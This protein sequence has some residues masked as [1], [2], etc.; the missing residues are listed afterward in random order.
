V[1]L[2]SVSAHETLVS[3]PIG[4][5]QEEAELVVAGTVEE[6]RGLWRR[7]RADFAATVIQQSFLDVGEALFGSY[8]QL[9]PGSPVR[10][11]LELNRQ[12]ARAAAEDGV[13]L[14]DVTRPAARD[15]LSAWFDAARWFQ[16]K[17]E[18]APQAAPMYG[19]LALRLVGARRG[20]SKKCLVLDL[21]DTLWGGVIGDVGLEGIVLGE[22]SAVGEA[23]LAL[24]RYAKALRARGILLA[25]CSKNEASVAET[26]FSDH[27]E[28][29]LRRDDVAAFVVNWTDKA[30]NL[31]TIA[32]QL[33][34]GLDSLV[35][36]DDNPVERAR[37]REALP[38]V[39]VP[40]L[41]PDPADFVRCVA[42]AGY[43]EAAQFTDEDRQRVHQYA[44]NT[45]RESLRAG[46]QTLDDFLR[47]L[48][49]SVVYGPVTPVEFARSSQ[50]IAKTNQFNTTTRRYTDAELAA[51]VYAPEN[52]ALHFRLV[53]RFGDNGI[54]SVLML[55]PDAGDP[56][57]FDVVCWVMSCRVFGRQLEHEVMNIAV[58]TVRARGARA[59]R[60]EL[61][62][63]PRN[64]VIKD[65]FPGLGF[66]RID[67]PAPEGTTRW[68]VD[69]V[70][71][72]ARPTFIKRAPA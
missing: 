44:A 56:D 3:I 49:M 71:Y 37:V 17:I 58:E 31:Q 62:P 27:P 4:A 20:L 22:G 15:G 45:Q 67:G 23:H 63:T 51:L 2:L 29:L 10:V 13:S 69:L 61:I 36:V 25:V 28:M 68:G 39:A 41:P 1:V 50:L 53:D 14:L 5:T 35:F 52:V 21:D 9:V 60:A 32:E 12:L 33:N 11:V 16:G 66:A 7:A 34:I 54:V 47:Q 57:V 26:A 48:D 70:D 40:E 43:F 24:Q 38:M 8:D 55:R 30:R 64:A 59:L 42:D 46:V 19:E 72:E 65:L 18:I 6:L